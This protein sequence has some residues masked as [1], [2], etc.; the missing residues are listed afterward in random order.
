MDLNDPF[1]R[2]SFSM[3]LEVYDRIIEEAAS[4]HRKIGFL[5]V[6][7]RPRVIASSYQ[8][9]MIEHSPRFQRFAE[10]EDELARKYTDFFRSRGVATIDTLPYLVDSYRRARDADV[11]FWPDVKD[12][13]PLEEGYEALARAAADLAHAWG[14]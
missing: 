3:S 6:R 7:A 11:P 12:D 9:L 5:L 14:E 13:H 2:A 1:V 10:L 4:R 8:D